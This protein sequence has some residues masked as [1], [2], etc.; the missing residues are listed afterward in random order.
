MNPTKLSECCD[1]SLKAYLG[2]LYLNNSLDMYIGVKENQL[3]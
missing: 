2:L 1:I 3:E